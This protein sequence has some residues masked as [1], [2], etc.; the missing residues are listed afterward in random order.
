M[1][2]YVSIFLV[3]TT[4]LLTTQCRWGSNRNKTI[5]ADG[6]HLFGQYCAR[7]HRAAG[8]GGPA[9]GNGLSAPD[10]TQL[11]LS[12]QDIVNVI[13]NGFGEMPAFAD[14][15]SPVGV[16]LIAAYVVDDVEHRPVTGTQLPH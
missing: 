6:A 8:T 3:L 11:S 15:I 5:V 7:C 14:S 1:K 2:K 9:P 10:I 4:A 12:K 16:S 13:T